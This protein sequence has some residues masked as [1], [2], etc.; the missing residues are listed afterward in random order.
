MYS[1]AIIFQGLGNGI[2]STLTSQLIPIL[3]NSTNTNCRH[4][5]GKINYV[6]S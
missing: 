6:P 1:L 4:F 3:G 2:F 5:Q